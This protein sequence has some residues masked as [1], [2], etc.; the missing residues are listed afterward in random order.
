MKLAIGCDEAGYKLKE[1]IK[2]HLAECG[3]AVTD[4]G[5]ADGETALYPNIAFAVANSVAGQNH[6]RA[7][8][9]CGTGIG[10]CISANKVVGVRA[11]QAHDTY[12]AE[13]AKKSNNAQILCLGALVIGYELAKTIVDA[14]RNSHFEPGR[15]S[16]KVNLIV[17]YEAANKTI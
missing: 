3:Q 2:A 12:S 9:I 8:L 10:M 7:I 1:I 14:W 13:R 16:P 17:Q 11:A 4:F 15:S 5:V 6:D